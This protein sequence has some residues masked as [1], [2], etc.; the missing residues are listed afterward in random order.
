VPV[1]VIAEGGS[2]HDGE[3]HK[4]LAL[5]DAAATSGADAFK[6]Q[7]WSDPDQLADRRRV[8]PRYRDIYH[9]YAIPEQWL[10]DLSARCV[11]RRIKF[12]CTA[13]LPQDVATIARYTRVL[14]VASF[15]AEAPDM[16]EAMRPYRQPLGYLV[17]V[18][19]GMGAS[20]L[21]WLETGRVAS[22]KFLRCVSAYP[23]P[24]DALNLALLRSNTYDGL[25][26]HTD[27]SLTWTG[28]LATAAGAQLIEAHLRVPETITVNPDAPHAMTPR[29]FAEYVRHIRFA[30]TCLGTDTNALAPLP[31]ETEMAAYRV[32]T[33]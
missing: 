9:R 3:F 8:P 6:A 32:R 26:D 22:I 1:W 14:K 5:V 2:C 12:A 16:V 7:Y 25:S 19:L 24:C 28:A 11:E 31:C 21:Q 29:Q 33:T 27:P 30:E 10:A 15:E 18:S 23:A 4:A 13:Y 17:I 20:R